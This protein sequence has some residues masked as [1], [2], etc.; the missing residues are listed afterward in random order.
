M[1]KVQKKILVSDNLSNK[2][3]RLENL[4]FPE[5]NEGDYDIIYVDSNN[6]IYVNYSSSILATLYVK[7]NGEDTRLAAKVS[8]NRIYVYHRE[9]TFS[10]NFG[11]VTSIYNTINPT[12]TLYNCIKLNLN[13]NIKF[14]N[15]NV[16]N[17]YF[18]GTQTSDVYFNL[19]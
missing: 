15:N 5:S 14:N 4:S 6:K 1:A 12:K 17:I 18:N 8:S 19:G 10:S 9:H 7:E 2:T 11:A 16:S 13:V 3:I